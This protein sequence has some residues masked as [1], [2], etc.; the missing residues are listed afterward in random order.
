LIE[1][2]YEFGFFPIS[3]HG[4]GTGNGDICACPIPIPK[5][6]LTNVCIGKINIYFNY[7]LTNRYI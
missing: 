2:G 5:L 4:Y 6:I 3:K 7:L 1:F